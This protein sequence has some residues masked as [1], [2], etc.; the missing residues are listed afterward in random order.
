MQE[1]NLLSNTQRSDRLLRSKLSILRKTL[2]VRGVEVSVI[3][4]TNSVRSKVHGFN[5]IDLDGDRADETAYKQIRLVLNLNN[6]DHVGDKAMNNQICYHVEDIGDEGDIIK[7]TGRVYEYA[8]KIERKQVYGE[9]DFLYE[10]EL[11]HFRT[12]RIAPGGVPEVIYDAKEIDKEFKD[13]NSGHNPEIPDPP[14]PDWRNRIDELDK[15]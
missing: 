4:S 2:R 6:L 12:I 15:I 7:Y 10:Y 8:F 5:D 3:K 14:H 1:P 11:N 13:H 9:E